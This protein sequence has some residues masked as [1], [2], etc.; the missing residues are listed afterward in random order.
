MAAES[1]DQQPQPVTARGQDRP[2][3]AAAGHRG[4]HPPAPTGTT[5]VAALQ[6]SPLREIEI[7]RFSVRAPARDVE[8]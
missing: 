2:E 8:L 4:G 5:I 3:S 1:G 6:D 7:E